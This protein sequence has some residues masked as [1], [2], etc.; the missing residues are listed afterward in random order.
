[1]SAERQRSKSI[2]YYSI[3]DGSQPN[4][5]MRIPAIHPSPRTAPF[6]ITGCRLLLELS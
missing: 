5:L 6:P 2:A 4:T 3:T 1:M